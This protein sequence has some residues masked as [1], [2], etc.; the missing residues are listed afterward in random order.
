M[1]NPHM[2]KIQHPAAADVFSCYSGGA[3]ASQVI[4]LAEG[5]SVIFV[6]D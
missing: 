5:Q 4:C 2:F 3:A 6:Q 1:S